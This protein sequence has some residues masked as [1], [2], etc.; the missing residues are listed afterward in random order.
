[1]LGRL[2][3]E[4]FKALSGEAQKAILLSGFII[5]FVMGVLII[6]GTLKKTR[7]GINLEPPPCPQ[8]GTPSSGIRIARSMRQFMWGG[9]TCPKCGC[10]IDKWG[11]DISPN[12]SAVTPP[13]LP[14]ADSEPS[15]K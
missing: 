8:C 3:V 10:E 6:H 15:K 9:R 2:L 12:R 13:A 4:D 5:W 7:W 14:R 11:R 1:M